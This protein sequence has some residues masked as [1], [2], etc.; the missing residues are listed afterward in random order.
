M[1]NY[2]F[3]G[4]TP[5]KF[6]V[7]EYLLPLNPKELK[8]SQ[9]G[10]NITQDVIGLGD[11][12]IL[13]KPGL[14]TFTIE[15]FFPQQI[16]STFFGLD[17]LRLNKKL[18][19][20]DQYINYFKSV[21]TNKN[22]VRVVITQLDISMLMSIEKF[23][24][25][26]FAGEHNDRYYEM[27]LKEY[28]KYG[29]KKLVAQ[30]DSAGNITY[31]EQQSTTQ[32]VTLGIKEIPE[33]YNVKQEQ[34]IW[35]VAKQTTGNGENYIDIINDNLDYFKSGLESVVGQSVNIPIKLRK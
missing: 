30:K 19:T 20:V 34:S 27:E 35:E 4:L 28:P 24:I 5:I 32:D 8:V 1:M 18:P 22:L 7:G 15:S 17:P 23:D 16:T 26:T 29:A 33:S 3:G 21:E 11:I 6:Y 10:R 13:R 14:K 9:A 31:V 12:T 25:S 2:F